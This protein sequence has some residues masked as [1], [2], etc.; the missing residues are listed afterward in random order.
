MRARTHTHTSTHTHTHSCF[1]SRAACCLQDG[2]TALHRAAFKGHMQVVTALLAAGAD[3]NLQS[4]VRN[5][6]LR[7]VRVRGRVRVVVGGC[8]IYG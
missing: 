6:W 5:C 2:D 4:K 1:P 3:I 7:R 8:C